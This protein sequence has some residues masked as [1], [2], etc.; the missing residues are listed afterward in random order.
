MNGVWTEFIKLRQT[1]GDWG[2]ALKI[3][4][5]NPSKGG[6]QKEIIRFLYETPNYPKRAGKVDWKD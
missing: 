6:K 5:S 3:V 4:D 2:F 1:N